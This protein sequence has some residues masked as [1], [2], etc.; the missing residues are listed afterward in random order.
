MALLLYGRGETIRAT[1][2]DKHFIALTCEKIGALVSSSGICR[3]CDVICDGTGGGSPI[4]D[5]MSCGGSATGI[6]DGP[7]AA[8]PRT[9]LS[10]SL[11]A[12]SYEAGKLGARAI[13]GATTDVGDGDGFPLGASAASMSST[14][15]DVVGSSAHLQGTPRRGV[16]KENKC[17]GF[18]SSCG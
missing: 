15:V 1:A 13:G 4:C 6:R 3:C 18:G 17:C 2:D 16:R 10:P 11:A 8:R 14:V 7:A 12:R 5:G 9:P